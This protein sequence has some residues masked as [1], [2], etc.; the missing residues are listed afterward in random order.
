MG[1]GGP[2]TLFKENETRIL[3]PKHR[4]VL[5]TIP[6]EVPANLRHDLLEAARLLEPSPKASAALSR[7]LLQNIFHHEMGIKKRNLD[8]EIEFFIAESRAPSYLTDAVDMI[9]VAGN[10][11]AHPLKY[12]SVDKIVDV[13][14]GEAEWALEVLVAMLDFVFVQPARLRRRR[15]EVN[16]K[17]AEAGKPL[18]KS[19]DDS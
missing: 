9:R 1:V 5:P 3:F 19:G 18:L 17:L 4:G 2:N 15:D 11:A 10:F 14:P 6:P 12:E 16:A 7:R 8:A 13:E